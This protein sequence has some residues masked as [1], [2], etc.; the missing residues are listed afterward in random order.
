MLWYFPEAKILKLEVETI[1]LFAHSPFTGLRPRGV[2]FHGATGTGKTQAA[3]YLARQMGVITYRLDA[4][5][6]MNRYVGDSEKNMA[7]ALKYLELAAPCVF[8]LDEVEK[9][10]S[11][12]GDDSGVGLRML[13]N[14]LW[15]LEEHTSEIFTIMTTN[16]I[17]AIPQEL[18]RPGRVDS[19]IWLKGLTGIEIEPFIKSWAEYI[20]V[21]I[22]ELP[23]ATQIPH[24]SASAGSGDYARWFPAEVVTHLSNVV[25]KL[26]VDKL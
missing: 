10:F 13:S 9:M 25:A 16:D 18:I 23:D 17:N 14:L 12:L 21:S 5:T 15:W 2:L 3:K 26:K 24:D 1:P 20:G 8:L 6:T 19:K 7:A 11:G 22:S 4:G